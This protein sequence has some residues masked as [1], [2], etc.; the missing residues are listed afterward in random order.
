M[1]VLC[2]NWLGSC[3]RAKKR[4]FENKWLVGATTLPTMLEWREYTALQTSQCLPRIYPTE[5]FPT[6]TKDSNMF[7][8]AVSPGRRRRGAT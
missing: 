3:E 6:S 8:Y 5:N 2:I 7:A 4:G 1:Y